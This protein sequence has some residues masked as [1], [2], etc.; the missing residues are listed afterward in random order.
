MRE[1]IA[2]I[3]Q[4]RVDADQESHVEVFPSRGVYDTGKDNNMDVEWSKYTQQSS[5]RFRQSSPAWWV[6]GEK[7]REQLEEIRG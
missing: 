7:S 6:K 2:N 1:W 3:A 5:R 4:N